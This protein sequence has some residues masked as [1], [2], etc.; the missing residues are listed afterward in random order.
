M[1]QKKKILINPDTLEISSNSRAKKKSR[2]EKTHNKTQKLSPIKQKL[3]NKIKQHKKRKATEKQTSEQG[4]FV[5]EFTE[6]MNYLKNL[7]KKKYN[8]KKTKINLQLPNDLNKQQFSNLEV[9]NNDILQNITN[10]PY[11]NLKNG[12][13]PT[14]RTW[15]QT[16]RK[17]PLTNHIDTQSNLDITTPQ[18]SI[19]PTTTTPSPATLNNNIT[20]VANEISIADNLSALDSTPLSPT[21]NKEKNANAMPLFTSKELT[22]IN[23]IDSKE[24]EKIIDERKQNIIQSKIRENNSDKYRS[25]NNIKM[26]KISKKY[27]LG[28]HNDQITVLLKNNKTRKNINNEKNILKKKSILEIKDYLR[29]HNLLKIGST[30]PEEVIR[31]MYESAMLTGNVKNKNEEVLVHNFLS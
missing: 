21:V 8:K 4:I 19:V 11:G 5:N 14:Y 2:K 9:T 15:K 7:T 27:K 30:A 12:N 25:K 1:D 29:K 24:S 18:M 22:A 3:L 6:S 23:N 28:K 10:P 17:A 31:S 13:K 16:T 20:D 26:H